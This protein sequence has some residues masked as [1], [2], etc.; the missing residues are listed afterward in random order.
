MALFESDERQ[1]MLHVSL[2][3]NNKKLLIQKANAYCS[4]F[5]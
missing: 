5:R 4:F 2:E 3:I 1:T